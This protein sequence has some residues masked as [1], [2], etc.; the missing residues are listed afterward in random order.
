MLSYLNYAPLGEGVWCDESLPPISDA[1]KAD[2]DPGTVATEIETDRKTTG[3][4][5]IG[6]T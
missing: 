3:F 4:S 2:T 1:D 6:L 5:K